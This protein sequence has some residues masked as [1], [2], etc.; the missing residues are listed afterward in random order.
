MPLGSRPAWARIICEPNDDGETFATS[1]QSISYPIFN[2]L[3]EG[4][5]KKKIS[6]QRFI[7]NWQ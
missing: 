4:E 3:G 6:C 7:D 2:N 5:L 1:K